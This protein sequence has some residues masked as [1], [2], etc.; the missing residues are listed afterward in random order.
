[1]VDS[2]GVETSDQTKVLIH[3]ADSMPLTFYVTVTGTSVWEVRPGDVM[4]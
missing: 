2:R 3:L 4:A 1:M